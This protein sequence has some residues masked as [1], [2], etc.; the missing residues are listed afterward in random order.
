[1]GCRRGYEATLERLK[2]PILRKKIIEGIKENIPWI[3]TLPP[4]GTFTHLKK[5]EAY[6]GMDFRDVAKERNQSLE[7]MICDI[8]A[9][10]NLEVGTNVNPSVDIKKRE[11]M[12]KD[13]VWLLSKPYYMVGT[14]GI[15]VGF[16]PHPR[17]FGTFPR[18][19]NLAKQY[20]MPY[21]IFANRTSYFPAEV[22]KLKN[23]GKIA[24]KYY[25][26][27]I[28]FN[29]VTIKDNATYNNPRRGPDGIEYVV[30]N[31]KI[32]VYKEKVTGLFASQKIRREN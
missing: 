7:D 19:L 24:K 16:K 8:L 15:P 25:A 27:I 29:P 28:V 17:A 22:F 30:V 31:G 2:N 13:F 6:I 20:G 14:D 32:A 23:R 5:N 3:D 1:M 26:G 4:G 10:E 12:K 9:E 18:F 21:E 11:Q